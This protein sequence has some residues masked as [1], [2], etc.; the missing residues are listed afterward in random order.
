MLAGGEPEDV[1]A[2]KK[3][4]VL[5][6]EVGVEVGVGQ[7]HKQGVN[8][9]RSVNVVAATGNFEEIDANFIRFKIGDVI[10]R[11]SWRCLLPFRVPV[12]GVGNGLLL[13]ALGGL[14][15]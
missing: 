7:R 8:F 10:V 15:W 13:R 1:A 6:A 2:V 5:A 12:R 11:G 4:D 14:P 9:R 3:R